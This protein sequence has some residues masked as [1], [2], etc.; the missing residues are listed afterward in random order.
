MIILD[1]T[2]KKLQ[3]YTLATPTT[4]LTYYVSYIDMSS[5]A[6]S[7]IASN[8]GT[9]DETETDIVSAPSASTQR[10]IKYISLYNAD[11]Q[12]HTVTVVIDISGVNTILAQVLLQAGYTFTYNNDGKWEIING[13]QI[14]DEGF[15]LNVVT[16]EPPTPSEGTLQ[17]YAKNIGGRAMLKWR[18]PSGLDVPIQPALFQNNILMMLPQT[19]TTIT[20]WGTTNTSVGTVSHPAITSTGL[21]S[22]MRRWR[23]TSAATANSAAE[24]RTNTYLVWRGDSPGL[25]GWY[26]TCRWALS[27]STANQQVAI[28]L[29]GSTGATST[30][31]VPS[32]L[33]NCI[34]VGW[35][36]ADTYLQIMHNDGSG[37]CTKIDLGSNFPTNS[38]DSIYEFVMFAPPNG[39]SV[40]Y[41][42]VLLNTGDIAE[43]EIT[44]DLPSQSTL[45]TRHEYANNG[46]TANSVVL[47]ISRIYIETDY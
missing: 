34:F 13:A 9:F 6:V 1:S 24:G 35:D 29:W 21:L 7:N 10:Q 47:E 36:S 31:I 28:G 20:L 25:G 19:G 41:R 38:P 43:G 22:S 45:L 18:G 42:L 46:G 32:D 12:P 2:T 40:F 14:M 23:W 27:S 17:F 44:T 26:Y 16:E 5:L 30:S 4:A 33:T 37:T 11:N 39:S 3:A 15:L 8:N